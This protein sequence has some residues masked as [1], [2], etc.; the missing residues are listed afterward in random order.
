MKHF[1]I[2]CLV[3]ALITPLL[4]AETEESQEDRIRRLEAENKALRATMRQLVEEN[5]ALKAKLQAL[6]QE[7]QIDEASAETPSKEEKAEEEKPGSPLKPMKEFGKA[8][9][10]GQA[11]PVLRMKV[12]QIQGPKDMLTEFRFSKG[13]ALWGPSAS[14]PRYGHFVVWI[15]GIDTAG[16]VDGQ[17]AEIGRPLKVTG[18]KSY[19]TLAGQ[20]T[21]FLLEPT[22]EQETQIV[23]REIKRLE[24]IERAKNRKQGT[25]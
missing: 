13:Y 4:L 21:V 16:M 25:R 11:A 22:T 15:H 1:V 8:L 3:V 18:T 12:I 7:P 6:K 14:A 17:W 20:R 10:L 19:E 23:E 24:R 5:K 9:A 2:V